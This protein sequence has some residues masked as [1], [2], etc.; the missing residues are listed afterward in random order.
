VGEKN[1]LSAP[2]RGRPKGKSLLLPPRGRQELLITGRGTKEEVFTKNGA[3]GPP[4]R[5][6]GYRE[7]TT[8]NERRGERYFYPREGQRKGRAWRITRK[9]RGCAGKSRG[10]EGA[11]G[12]GKGK[13]GGERKQGSLP[14]REGRGTCPEVRGE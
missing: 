13:H 8:L 5:G 10:R 11:P 1:S 7:A 3:S 6:K 4:L 2:K 12:R 9:E 14:L